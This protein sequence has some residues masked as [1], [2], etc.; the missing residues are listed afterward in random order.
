MASRGLSRLSG[1]NNSCRGKKAPGERGLPTGGVLLA[2]HGI[3]DT[4][5]SVLSLSSRLIG[6]AFGF[7]LLITSHLAGRFLDRALDLLGGTLDAIF[8][9]S[10]NSFA[11]AGG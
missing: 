1:L 7:S 2:L 5:N 8:V 10:S 9:H 4:A 6:L 3:L 11:L